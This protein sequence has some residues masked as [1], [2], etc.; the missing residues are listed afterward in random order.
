MT[1]II[2]DLDETPMIRLIKDKTDFQ[3]LVSDTKHY[4][5]L[6]IEYPAIYT[7]RYWDNPNGPADMYWEEAASGSKAISIVEEN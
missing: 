5:Y 4:I 3:R 1:K 7:G 6:P 2:I